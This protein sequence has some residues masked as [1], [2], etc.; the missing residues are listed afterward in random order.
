QDNYPLSTTQAVPLPIVSEQD[1]YLS[2]PHNSIISR[3]PL[4]PNSPDEMSS[5]T[6]ASSSPSPSLPSTHETS[7]LSPS[8]DHSSTVSP[9]QSS[10]PSPIAPSRPQRARQVPIRLRDYVCGLVTAVGS[11]PPSSSS[12]SS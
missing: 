10:S 11:S 5:S 2:S 6:P 12:P 7:N 4:S 9:D 8:P 1:N 3:A